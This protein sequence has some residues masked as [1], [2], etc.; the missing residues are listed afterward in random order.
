M[1]EENEKS[2]FDW[3]CNK[4]DTPMTNIVSEVVGGLENKYFSPTNL[5]NETSAAAGLDDILGSTMGDVTQDRLDNFD[6]SRV[7]DELNKTKEVV[8][9]NPP[10][11]E[12]E[13]PSMDSLV[14]EN[15]FYGGAMSAR[16]TSFG[17]SRWAR[18]FKKVQ[19]K[20]TRQMK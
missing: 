1:S 4:P 2:V 14:M 10:K 9:K 15:S 13:A 5:Q 6:W 3:L 18:K 12:I 11:I 17:N 20:K 19:T 7:D 16:S 8:S